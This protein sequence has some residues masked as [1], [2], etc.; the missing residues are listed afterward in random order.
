MCNSP[1]HSLDFLNLHQ[2][3]V[4]TKVMG[5][6]DSLENPPMS[7]IFQ[8]INNDNDEKTYATLEPVDFSDK[9][10]MVLYC[11][12]NFIITIQLFRY[13]TTKK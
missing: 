4:E 7:D 1:V 10:Q 9:M 2:E 13:S 8:C 3:T 11:V 12:L 5:Y 6:L